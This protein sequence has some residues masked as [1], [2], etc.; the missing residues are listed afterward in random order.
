MATVRGT[1]IRSFGT[2]QVATRT[3]GSIPYKA[4][5][6]N[7]INLGWFA[8]AR[9]GQAKIEQSVGHLLRWRLEVRQDLVESYVGED[10]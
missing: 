1:V 7:G 9:E 3:G 5:L 8:S 4:N 6:V 2:I 10:P